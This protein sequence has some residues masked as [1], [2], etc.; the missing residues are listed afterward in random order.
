MQ[1]L[2][3]MSDLAIDEENRLLLLSD[4][5]RSIA[6]IERTL[7]NLRGG[8]E[9]RHQ[10]DLQPPIER[11]QTRRSRVRRREAVRRGRQQARDWLFEIKTLP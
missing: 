7:E 11:E 10:G 2:S 9:D 5:G 3:D 6:R 1:T 4:Q 8:G